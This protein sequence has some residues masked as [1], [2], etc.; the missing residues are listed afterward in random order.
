MD[1]K[2]NTERKKAMFLVLYEE[3]ADR[4]LVS[5]E[6]KAHF[7]D[8]LAS[9][10]GDYRKGML[11]DVGL[12]DSIIGELQKAFPEVY[13]ATFDICKKLDEVDWHDLHLEEYS[14]TKSKLLKHPRI[15]VQFVS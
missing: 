1:F 12:R 15:A 5:D 8:F 4:L 9:F 11:S 6:V 2:L 14:I 13:F 7:Y 3:V 10:S